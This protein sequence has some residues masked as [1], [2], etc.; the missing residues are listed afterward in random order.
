MS[1]CLQLINSFFI[2]I[3]DNILMKKC[4]ICHVYLA[5]YFNTDEEIADA[6]YL[7]SFGKK[8]ILGA[9]LRNKCRRCYEKDI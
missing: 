4:N 9:R 6:S 3:I 2:I 8:L 7:S 5:R 1:L